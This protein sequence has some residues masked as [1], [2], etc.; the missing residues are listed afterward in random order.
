MLRIRN[1]AATFVVALA[2][3]AMLHTTPAGAA[4]GSVY[5][6]ITKASF[7]VGVAGGSG[8]LQF[9]G[10]T[11]RLDVSGLKAG[12]TIGV[13]SV[14]LVGTATGLMTARDIEGTYTSATG[15]ATLGGGVSSVVLENNRGVRI[16]LRGRQVGLEA[17][18]DLGGI[19][20][21][22]K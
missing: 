8:T 14:E 17:S 22:M 7:V 3:A 11:Y 15:S 16:N 10:K 19:T 6:K 21:R 1:I 5:I 2:M 20:I 13:A 12:L 9:G 4:S 18:L